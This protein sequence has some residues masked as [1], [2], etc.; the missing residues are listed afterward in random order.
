MARWNFYDYINTNKES[1]DAWKDSIELTYRFNN[2]TAYQIFEVAFRALMSSGVMQKHKHKGH[3]LSFGGYS[4]DCFPDNIVKQTNLSDILRNT[5]DPLKNIS[6]INDVCNQVFSSREQELGQTFIFIDKL[7]NLNRAMTHYNDFL[8]SLDAKFV[9]GNPTIE[10]SMKEHLIEEFK[11]AIAKGLEVADRSPDEMI[12]FADDGTYTMKIQPHLYTYFN[13]YI[14]GS[15]IYWG[16]ILKKL[17]SKNGKPNPN[18]PINSFIKDKIKY[19]HLRNKSQDIK[20]DDEFF[21]KF[22]NVERI[23]KRVEGSKSFAL[24]KTREEYFLESNLG[25]KFIDS[26]IELSGITTKDLNSSKDWDERTKRVIPKKSET[27]E[28]EPVW[29]TLKIGTGDDSK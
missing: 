18:T 11:K 14:V 3:V 24:F 10:P 16:Y 5:K 21:E 28:E 27:K 17:F 23:R 9:S 6:Q 26:V 19:D 12:S 4:Y 22:F 29:M 25:E 8:R 13:D 1:A 15:Y 7:E 20:F 2:F